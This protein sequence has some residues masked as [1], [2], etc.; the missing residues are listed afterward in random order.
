MRALLAPLLFALLNMEALAQTA[1]AANPPAAAPAG[2]TQTWYMADAE[3]K[4]GDGIVAVYLRNATFTLFSS[5]D[6]KSSYLTSITTM[7]GRREALCWRNYLLKC[8]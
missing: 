1:P 8:V 6:K 7:R 3:I 4:R 5:E 2:N